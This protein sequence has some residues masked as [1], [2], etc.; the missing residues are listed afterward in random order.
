EEYNFTEE[1]DKFQLNSLTKFLFDKYGFE[2]YLENEELPEDL[3][4]NRCK[5]LFADVENESGL[6]VTKLVVVLKDCQN[7]KVFVSEEGRSRD[8]EFKT[9]YQQALRDAFV[10]IA[11]LNYNYQPTKTLVEKTVIVSA[12][13]S[14]TETKQDSI[15]EVSAIP[16]VIQKTQDSIVEVSAIPSMIEK[17]QDSIVEVSAVPSLTEKEQDSIVEVSAIP[18]ELKDAEI[19]AE[20]GTE[21]KNFTS[22]EEMTFTMGQ[23]V[24]SLKKSGNGYNLF[25]KG[26]FEPFASL[27]ASE[28]NDS[29]IYSSI[30]AQGIAN[31]DEEG[32]LVVEIL[33]KE[34]NSVET[35]LYERQ[36]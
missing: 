2:A 22:S 21:N 13:P 26:M 6:F 31:F 28:S 27:I 25:Q 4:S 8:K 10:S 12:V 3:K 15:V 23:G 30:T 14:V 32:N 24:Y 35:R 1:P 34:T 36:D 17:E 5:A 33:N 20:I 9:A 18:G 11:A 7:E 19:S 29:F 16:S